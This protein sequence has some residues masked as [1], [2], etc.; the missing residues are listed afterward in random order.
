MH[1]KLIDLRKL[2]D[3]LFRIFKS[4]IS[5]KQHVSG[6]EVFE[7]TSMLHLPHLKVLVRKGSG[8]SLPSM[9]IE[10]LT[11]HSRHMTLGNTALE[12]APDRIEG[13]TNQ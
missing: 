3:T 8:I 4:F 9:P 1:E 5:N 6:G 11:R 13:I 2:L 7:D 10:S 12:L